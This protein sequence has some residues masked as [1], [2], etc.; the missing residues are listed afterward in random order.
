MVV[1]RYPIWGAGLFDLSAGGKNIG[2]TRPYTSGRD[3]I[4]RCSSES[5]A[6]KGS[7]SSRLFVRLPT[8]LLYL[9][10]FFSKNNT[11]G[12]CLIFL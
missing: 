2:K 7:A 3:L 5:N 10:N 4:R 6:I 1:H 9:T 12:I 11:C 8:P